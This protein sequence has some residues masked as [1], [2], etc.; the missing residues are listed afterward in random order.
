M[1]IPAGY[2]FYN[3]YNSMQNPSTVHITNTGLS[4]YYRRYML[5]KL[6]AVYKFEGIPEHW[7]ENYFLYSLFTFGFV[8]VIKTDKFGV[9]PQ[10][11]S[12]YGYN[13]MYQPTNV[14]IA[15]PLIDRTMQPRIGSE[16]ALIKMQPD[17]GSAWDIICH[18][19]DLKALACEAAAVNLINSKLAY[20]FAAESKSAAESFKKLYDQIANGQ[21]ATFIDKALFDDEGNPR[22]FTFGQNLKQNY[23]VSDL[24]SDMA[25][26]DSK[27][28]T[29]IGIPNVNLAKES[30]VSQSEIMSNNV[31]TRS[32]ASLWLEE[33]RKG[34]K[35][36]ND[37]FGLDLSVDFRF[38]ESEVMQDGNDSFDTRSL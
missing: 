14:M 21:P 19:G 26:L 11:C 20:V 30:G 31:E 4:N 12:L 6:L 29:E 5:Q 27:F 35:Q 13:V 24:L 33:I 3:T 32:K 36:A 8:S 34:L 7:A 38:N 16:C 2:E 10:H 25:K 1:T 18:Y 28:D 17:Y 37:L 9:I 15:N 23:I 22:W